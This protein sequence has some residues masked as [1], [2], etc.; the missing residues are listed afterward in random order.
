M[1]IEDNEYI[2]SEGDSLHFPSHLSHTWFN[3]TEE[4]VQILCILTLVI[5]Q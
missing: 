3:S 2:L 5:F 1:V 4:A